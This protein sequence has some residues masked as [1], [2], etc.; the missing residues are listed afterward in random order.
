MVNSTRLSSLGS[1]T[2]PKTRRFRKKNLGWAVPLLLGSG[3]GLLGLASFIKPSST[4]NPSVS[5][6]FRIL[7]TVTSGGNNANSTSNLT[8]CGTFGMESW[9]TCECSPGISC[10]NVK[11]STAELIPGVHADAV[12]IDQGAGHAVL[13]LLVMTYFFVYLAIVC[14]DYFC[15]SLDGIIDTLKLSPNVAGATFMAAGSSAPEFFVSFADN[16]ITQPPKSLGVGTIIGSAIFNVLVIIGVTAVMAQQTLS[17]DYR[18]LVRDCAWYILAIIMLICAVFDN[19]V[20]IYDSI[21]LMLGYVGYILCCWK[22]EAILEYFDP[23][24]SKNDVVHHQDGDNN[25]PGTQEEEKHSAVVLGSNDESKPLS[26]NSI[27]LTTSDANDPDEHAIPEPM[28]KE[29]HPLEKGSTDEGGNEPMLANDNGDE[30]TTSDSEEGYWDDLFFE[31]DS[32]I[33]EMNYFM[34]LAWYLLTIPIIMLLRTTIPDCSHD[35]FNNPWGIGLAFVMSVLHIAIVSH[36]LSYFAAIFG[37]IAGISIPV[38]GLT[39]MAAGTSVP[40]ALASI[41][42]GKRGE[43]DMAVANSLGSNV[44]DIML[45]LGVPYFIGILISGQNIAVTTGELYTSLIF[46]IVVVLAL[47]GTMHFANW[48]LNSKVGLIL[49]ALYCVFIVYSLLAQNIRIGPEY[50]PSQHTC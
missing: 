15:V 45:C 41:S 11:C 2:R 36:F 50:D 8:K 22:W 10:Y 48:K 35:R 14:D 43:G 20:Q 46:L 31:S 1:S 4:D 33:G 40:D 39:I 18:P 9:T 16:V 32:Q 12:C 19:C 21:Y 34:D 5:N 25:S 29:R 37:N 28:I 47:F 3:L 23:S 30:K 7:T 42:V 6:D 49:L 13:Y 44:F 26:A 27:E 38:M 24:N 17:I